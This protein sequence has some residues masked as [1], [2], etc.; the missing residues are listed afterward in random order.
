M[1]TTGH[2]HDNRIAGTVSIL[3]LAAAF[4]IGTYSIFKYN[5]PAAVFYF[6]AVL[7]G[8]FLNVFFFCRKCPHITDDS[9]RFVVFGKVACLFPKD[10]VGTPY[11]FRDVIMIWVPRIFMFFFP[12][13]W[14]IKEKVLFIIFWLLIVNALFLWVTYVCRTCRNEKCPFRKFTVPK[15]R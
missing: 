7:A 8:Y 3:S 5:V 9:C 11:S 13:P 6:I 2:L 1:K 14:I 10:R 12:R 4:C 15:P